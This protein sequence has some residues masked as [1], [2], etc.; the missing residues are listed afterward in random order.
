MRSFTQPPM[1]LH[2]VRA[3]TEQGARCVVRAQAAVKSGCNTGTAGS[4]QLWSWVIFL[5]VFR[6][7]FLLTAFVLLF[8]FFMALTFRTC[9]L[10]SHGADASLPVTWG[11]ECGSVDLVSLYFADFV[12][13]CWD[14]VS[15]C[16]FP[17]LV[18][19]RRVWLRT[20]SLP[21]SSFLLGAGNKRLLHPSSKV[22]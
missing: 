11:L 18:L 4:L 21:D 8:C 5:C 13:I 6:N 20:H 7:R 17:G 19:W 12:S 16:S 22:L 14:W 2:G 15:S 9:W 10:G 3:W 1:P